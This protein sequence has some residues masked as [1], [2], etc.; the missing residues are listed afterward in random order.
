MNTPFEELLP[1][2]AIAAVVVLVLVLAIISYVREA[3]RRQALIELG[4]R[5]NLNYQAKSYELARELSYIQW[6]NQG[7]DRY[8]FNIFS[9]L[10]KNREVMVFDYHYRTQ[11]TDSKGKRTYTHHYFSVL[12]LRQ[13]L[14]FPELRIYPENI[15]GRIGQALGFDD[16]DFESVEFSR[17][18]TV[19]SD[20]KKFAYDI[21][22]T[23]MMAYLLEHKGLHIEFENRTIALYFQDKLRVETIEE[24]LGYLIQIR[25]LIP[26]YLYRQ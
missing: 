8:A 19:R 5:L 16:I 11:N 24:R 14:A 13:E 4:A 25:E 15:L 17:A 10:Y 12:L 3:K 1:G 9:G 22:H 20:D 18:F 26:E 2:I 6:L 23:R 7:D 21:C